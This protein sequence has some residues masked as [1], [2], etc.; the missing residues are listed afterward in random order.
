[1]TLMPV[2]LKPKT[3]NLSPRFDRIDY[4]K[5][6][7]EIP[8]LI[9]PDEA[10]RLTEYARN[11]NLS[12]LHRR[13]SKNMW[14]SASFYTCM[15][16]FYED[17]IYNKLNYVWEQY[18]KQIQPNIEF[19]EPYEI[20]IYVENDKFERHHDGCVGINNPVNRKINLSLQ[21][22]DPDEYDG[23]NLLID[24]YVTS[25]AFGTGIFFPADVFHEVTPIT[26][27][28][29]VCLIGHAWGPYHK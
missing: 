17:P 8:N 18:A 5:E 4:A 1:M 24:D 10:K 9:T 2:H 14:T 21:L 20:K 3:I 26:R 19:I 27:G 22:S 23:G 12:G 16:F 15:L 28:A 25:R 29:R 13:G 7:I 6:I 11:D